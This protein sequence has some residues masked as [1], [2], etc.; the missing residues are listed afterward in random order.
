MP[1]GGVAKRPLHFFILADCSGSMAASGKIQALNVAVGELLPHLEDV[2]QENVHAQILVRAL[3]FSTGC[4][5][6]VAT[7]T[8]PAD[9]QWKPLR[10]QGTTDLGAALKDLSGQL[11][12]PP[13]E[14]R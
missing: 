9:L 8:A 11:S 4:T 1:G 10:A 5:W 2:S 3:S 13:M 12:S 7:P 14:P 6:H